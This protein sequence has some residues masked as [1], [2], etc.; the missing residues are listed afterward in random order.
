MK[1]RLGSAI[2][3]R[4]QSVLKGRSTGGFQTGGGVPN[5][6]SFFLLVPSVLSGTFLMLR[7]GFADWSFSSFS[8]YYSSCEERSRKGPRHNQDLSRKSGNPPP[9]WKPP[10]STSLNARND[11]LQVLLDIGAALSFW[12]LAEIFCAVTILVDVSDLFFLFRGGGEGG[13]VRGGGRGGRFFSFKYGGGGVSEEE[14][15]EGEG[16]RGNVCGEGGGAKYF[17][18]GRNAH[19][20]MRVRLR[21]LV[22]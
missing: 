11:V 4:G 22:R 8:A 3:L 9:V 18:C 17:I 21:G 7:G 14:A 20:A 15:R 16:R 5:L 10:G 19:Q 2:R 12:T 1:V 6:G 13:G